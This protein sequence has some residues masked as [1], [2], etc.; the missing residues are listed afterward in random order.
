MKRPRQLPM[1][2]LAIILASMF[3]WPAFGADT[4]S[5]TGSR[6][7]G[8]ARA[9]TVDINSATADELDALPG[10]GKATAKKI[11]ESRPYA[12]K[13]DLVDK[14]IVSQATYDKIQDRIVA[15]RSDDGAA[16]AAPRTGAS[17]DAGSSA[18]RTDTSRP[19]R[20]ESAPAVAGSQTP[21][22]GDVWVNTATGVYH[23]EG[24]RWYGKTKQG[25]YM[26]EDEAVRAGYHASKEGAAKQQG[27]AKQ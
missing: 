16:S 1:I 27:A 19:G 26:S 13:R 3:A 9:A 6:G 25:K 24:D 18:A 12:N 21:H 15:H 23:R 17:R 2:V 11:I 20:N 5:K 4:K 7:T 8:D 14:H 22:K 10:V